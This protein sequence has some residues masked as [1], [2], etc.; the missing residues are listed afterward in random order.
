[1]K[2]EYFNVRG[3]GKDIFTMSLTLHLAEVTQ[4]ESITNVLSLC[5]ISLATGLNDYQDHA[6]YNKY[7]ARAKEIGS[8]EKHQE[9]RRELYECILENMNDAP[10]NLLSCQDILEGVVERPLSS[11]LPA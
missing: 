6:S 5:R 10:A 7:V 4:Q 1:M 3:I 2:E 11:P 9:S 8:G